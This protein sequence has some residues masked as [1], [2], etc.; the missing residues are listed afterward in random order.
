MLDE[1]HQPARSAPVLVAQRQRLGLARAR[2]GRLGQRQ[3]PA[4]PTSSTTT[5]ATRIPSVVPKCPA[6]STVEDTAPA[7]T[8]RPGGS[9]PATPARGAPCV[10]ASSST[11][12]SMPRRCSRPCTTSSATSSSRL[13]PCSMALRAATDGTHH[14]VAEQGGHVVVVA[15]EPSSGPGPALVGGT[16]AELGLLVDGKGEHVGGPGLPEEPLVK[17][18]DGRLVDE[19]QRHLDVVLDTLRA[20]GR[21]VRASPNARCRWHVSD[22]SSAAKTSTATVLPP[23]SARAA[24]DG[25]RPRPVRAAAPRPVPSASSARS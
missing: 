24:C 13:T 11:S 3:E 4:D 19:E 25:G 9:G 18:G 17:L 5:T 1:A 16:P 10:S 21:R 22:C 2:P 14:H 6:A 20:R 8:E 12:W 15:R 23:C 7:P